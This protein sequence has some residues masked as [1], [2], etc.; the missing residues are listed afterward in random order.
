M[1]LEHYCI[2][3]ILNFDFTVVFKVAE[4]IALLEEWPKLPPENALE[5]L[6]Y[7]YAEPTVRSYAIECLTHI[8]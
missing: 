5:L 1:C 4:M 7:A 8:R 2:V 3:L 6:D